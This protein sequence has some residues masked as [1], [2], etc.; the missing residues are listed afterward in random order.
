MAIIKNEKELDDFTG[1]INAFLQTV[2]ILSQNIQFNSLVDGGAIVNVILVTF[3]YEYSSVK[4]FLSDIKG[5][6]AIQQ[7]TDLTSRL[8]GNGRG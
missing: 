5:A 2:R 4:Q 7:L 6:P 1:Q 8:T 3:E